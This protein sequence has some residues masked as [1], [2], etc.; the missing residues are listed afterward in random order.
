[1]IALSAKDKAMAFPMPRPAPVT[2][3]I[4]LSSWSDIVEILFMKK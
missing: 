2:N 4:F 3:A 1:M